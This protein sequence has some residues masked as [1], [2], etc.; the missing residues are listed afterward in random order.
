MSSLNDQATIDEIVKSN[1]KG[2]FTHKVQ[3]CSIRYFT[4]VKV[5]GT[6]KGS[7]ST[8]PLPTSASLVGKT[9]YDISMTKCP[10]IGIWNYGTGA[11][12]DI[13]R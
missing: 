7:L 1:G 10:V 6:L 5:L 3:L 2:G 4:G 8:T 13:N 12:N 9:P 11:S